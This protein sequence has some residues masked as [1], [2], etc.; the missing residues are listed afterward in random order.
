LLF[1]IRVMIA[2]RIYCFHI[3]FRGSRGGKRVGL[4][5][6]RGFC[7]FFFRTSSLQKK[8]ELP[9]DKFEKRP[10]TV[11]L[12]SQKEKSKDNFLRK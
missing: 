9:D 12:D 6:R 11:S 2:P 10:S 1:I 7:S 8:R 4:C 5:A 3:E